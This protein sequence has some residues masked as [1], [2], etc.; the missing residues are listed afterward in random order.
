MTGGRS[1][2]RRPTGGRR[3]AGTQGGGFTVRRSGRGLGGAAP[4]RCGRPASDRMATGCRPAGDRF[5]NSRDC[6]GM[7]GD[8]AADYAVY[9]LFTARKSALYRIVCRLIA[10]Y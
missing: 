5:Y 3:G 8:Y 4:V 1:D 6:A 2:G 9:E 7:L 10:G